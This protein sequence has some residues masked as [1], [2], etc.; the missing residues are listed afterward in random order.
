M[1]IKGEKR[2]KTRT[3]RDHVTG[4]EIVIA[5]E[6]TT[7]ER[8]I[9][10]K[11]GRTEKR[12]GIGK[13][14]A[15]R[16][17]TGPKIDKDKRTGRETEMVETKTA[18]LEIKT[19]KPNKR[20]EMSEIRTSKGKN[21]RTGT[22]RIK[23]RTKTKIKNVRRIGKNKKIRIKTRIKTRIKIEKRIDRK[24]ERKIRKKTRIKTGKKIVRKT[25]MFVTKIETIRKEKTKIRKIEIIEKRNLEIAQILAKTRDRDMGE[26][27]LAATEG[28]AIATIDTKEDQEI[29]LQGSIVST[30]PQKTRAQTNHK[31]LRRCKSS[32]T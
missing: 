22:E 6:I 19:K 13:K 17:L 7:T 12:I 25:E 14:T 11:T 26:V 29:E 31:T 16:T 1:T 20:I 32:T 21:K 30:V 18:T 3:A 9:V 5:I 2:K 27:D 4:T 23:T 8:E 28:I 15:K 10:E 24:I